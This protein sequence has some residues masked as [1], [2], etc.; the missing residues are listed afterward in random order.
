MFTAL[1]SLPAPADRLKAL[2]Q[3]WTDVR[4]LIAHHGCPVG[5]LAAE[6][7]NRTDRLAAHAAAL[8]EHFIDWERRQF[9]Q[10]GRS[11]DRD[12]AITLLARIQGA[13]LLTSSLGDP[14]IMTSQAQHIQDWIDSLISTNDAGTVT[15]AGRPPIGGS[16][17]C[18]GTRRYAG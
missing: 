11:D 5:S 18:T 3:S 1:D 10:M 16:G 4:E 12:L 9:Q 15:A 8:I 17:A 7:S 2:V 13:A 14:Q 6:L